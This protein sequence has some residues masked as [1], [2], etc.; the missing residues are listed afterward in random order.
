MPHPLKESPVKE[1][2]VSINSNDIVEARRVLDLESKA[3]DVLS[4]GLGEEFT[5][6]VQVLMGTKDRVIVTGMGKS[7]HVGHKIAS[8]LASTGTPSTFVHPAEASH[9]DLGMIT[10]NDTILALSNSG[11]TSELSDILAY[12]K[13]HSIP[14]IVIT[15]GGKSTLANTADVSLILPEMEEACPLGL[16]PTTSTAMMM[17]L[18][19]ALATAVLN[20]R[21][22]SAK[23]FGSLHPGGKLGQRLML[24]KKLMH[25]QSDMPLVPLETFMKE[26]LLQMTSYGFGCVGVVD[27][28]GDLQGMITDGDLR[29]HMDEGDL[30]KAKV[31][32]IMTPSPQMICATVLAE[33]ALARMNKK[34]I[35]S[36]FVVETSSDEDRKPIGIL[37]IHDCLRA[38]LV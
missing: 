2:P 4:K 30:M 21:G 15:S 5:A 33:E 14:L 31:T 8:T 36:F 29:R 23:D 13:R 3:L 26:A 18:G 22:F 16:A 37:H 12:A 20:H 35:T 25:T 9:G 19:D 6:I 1:S 10:K 24:V 27:S 34:G 32:D 38:G 17:A 28:S 11:E 7:G